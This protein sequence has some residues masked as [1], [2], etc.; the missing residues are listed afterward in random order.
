MSKGTLYLVATPIGNLEDVTLRAVEILRS[1]DLIACEDTRTSR[2]LLRRHGIGTP[3][4][5]LHRFSESRRIRTILERLHEGQNVA[6]IS[7]A[8]TPAIS[9][10]GARVVRA[11]LDAGFS[12]SP[13]PGPSAI[14][15][16]LSASGMEG[17]SFVY[18]GFVPKK[19]GPRKAF[20]ENLLAES[21]TAVFLET[22][23]R[24]KTT[25]KLAAQILGARRLVLMRELTKIHEE[26][27]TGPAQTILEEL[28]KR[29]SVKG[30]IILV[31]EGAAPS[32]P[33]IDLTEMVRTLMAEGLSGKRLADEAHRRFGVKKNEAY[34]TFLS[35]RGLQSGKASC[36]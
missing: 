6:L 26:I 14:T 21:R 9:D 34:S 15:A 22:P 4:L 32:K 30:E 12:V 2:V 18:L 36:S 1:V 8:G 29:P 17:S 25:L 3:V 33:D 35:L 20:L 7:D 19:P 10:P 16:A 13:I 24:V 31:F 27:L 5:S 11:A 23:L 28:D